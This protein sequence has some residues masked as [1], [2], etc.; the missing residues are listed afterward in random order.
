MCEGVRGGRGVF[1]GE[2]SEVGTEGKRKGRE[3]KE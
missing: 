1:Y 3:G 2:G